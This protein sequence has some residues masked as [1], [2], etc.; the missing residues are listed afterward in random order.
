ME[1]KKILIVDD[2]KDC[3]LAIAAELRLSGFKVVSAW[4][5]AGAVMMAVQEKPDLI[6][7]D[8]SLPAGSGIVVMQRITSISNIAMTP[9]IIITASDSTETKT[10]AFK[11]GAVAYFLKP[12]EFSEL[13]KAIH[14]ALSLPSPSTA[15]S[16][17]QY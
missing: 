5:A 4:D 1:Q 13:L 9:I 2:E 7:L 3:Q 12:F 10:E 16:K 11:N 14:K 8:I 15:G 6:L 17:P